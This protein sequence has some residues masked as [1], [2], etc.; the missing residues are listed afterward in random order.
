M[1]EFL[2][3]IGELIFGNKR[4]DE[5]VHFARSKDFQFRKKVKAKKLP[6]PVQQMDFFKD[7]KKQSI[8]GYLFKKDLELNSF[9][10]IF[11]FY[12]GSDYGNSGTT[13]FLYDC[14]GLDL[15]GFIIKP[16]GGFRKLGSI[17]S[18]GEW[19]HVNPEFEKAYTVESTDMNYMRMAITI[20]FAEVMLRLKG[21][22]LEGKGSH[23]VLY[24]K[25]TRTDI[26]DMD[27]IYFDGKELIDIIIHDHS[28]EIV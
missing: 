27:N 7:K 13:I 19:S 11:D 10:Q 22:S 26:V 16:K 14:E 28:E 8:K 20:Q 24:K 9:N 25:N 18:G 3:E 6:L 12:R 21:F 2:E 1:F 5:L 15:P 4:I 23:L 17:F